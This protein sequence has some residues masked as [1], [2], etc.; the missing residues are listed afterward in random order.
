MPFEVG[1][2]SIA[3]T[4]SSFHR[5]MGK[6]DLAR[7]LLTP[8]QMFLRPGHAA[9]TTVVAGPMEVR[10]RDEQIQTAT[11]DVSV[12]SLDGMDSKSLCSRCERQH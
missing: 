5:G 11:L 4:S 3:G 6:N 7:N 12:N 8:Y 10:L 9:A 2:S 1:T